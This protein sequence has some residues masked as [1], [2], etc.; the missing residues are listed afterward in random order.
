MP[1][2]KVVKRRGVFSGP[3]VDL[4]DDH[5]STE[6]PKIFDAASKNTIS[7]IVAHIT[8]IALSTTVPSSSAY[9]YAKAPV[10]TGCDQLRSYGKSLWNT[11]G[12]MQFSCWTLL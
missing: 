5:V 12:T 8:S 11:T 4:T 3:I 2:I 6:V 10:G 9:G 7:C 1:I